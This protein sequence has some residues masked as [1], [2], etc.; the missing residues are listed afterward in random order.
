[1]A[2]CGALA[3]SRCMCFYGAPKLTDGT[4]KSLWAAVA[5]LKASGQPWRYL[6]LACAAIFGASLRA[7]ACVFTRSETDGWHPEKRLGSRG[8]LKR[9]WAAVAIFGASLRGDIWS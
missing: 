4:L 2:I 8:T 6:E 9:F 3:Y 1:M 5:P 7:A